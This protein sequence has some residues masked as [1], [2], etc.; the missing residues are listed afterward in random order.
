MTSQKKVCLLFPFFEHGFIMRKVPLGL[1][2]IASGLEKEGIYVEAY[3]LNTDPLDAIDFTKFDYVG[4]TLLTP[5]ISEINK[6]C[7]IIRKANPKIKFVLGGTHATLA[8]DH[9]FE[10]IPDTDYVIRG[11]GEVS[12]AQLVLE[13]KDPGTIP[14]VFY[15]GTDGTILG[16]GQHTPDIH[17]LPFPNV[18]LF[19]HGNLEARN[20][21]RPILTSR[22]CPW[23]CKNCQPN[24]DIVQPYRLR[25]VDDVITEIIY[26]Q[27]TFGQ[28]YFGF[29]DSEFPIKKWWFE[30]LYAEIKRRKID[31]EFHCNARADLLDRDI[32]KMYKD[33]NISRLAIG[34]ESGVD[35]VVNGILNKRLDLKWTHEMFEA[36]D[37]AGIRTH[38]HFMIGMPGETLDDMQATLDYALKLAAT[39]IEFNFLTPWPGT[40]FFDICKENDYLVE[41]DVSKFN[42]K[43][44]PVV[45][46][47]DFTAE[48]VM[49][50]YYHLRRVLTNKGYHPTPDGTV[51]YHPSYDGD[52]LAPPPAARE[53]TRAAGYQE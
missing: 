42:E 32:F 4:M 45:S 2:Y 3:N 47:E 38:G 36:A 27:E 9:T 51:F 14:G 19:D 1:A 5:F 49:D 28:T 39:S 35:R 25:H 8:T 11:E 30:E 46:T 52:D 44:V 26:R 12:F 43:N 10:A 33:L 18:A 13:E 23:A 37:E 53:G 41:K 40:R 29:L 50:F 48:Q 16:L 31:F 6:L 24:L 15:R 21:L 17:S 20:P 7:K 22:G 34:V